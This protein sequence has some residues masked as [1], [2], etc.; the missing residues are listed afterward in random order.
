M[1]NTF[2]YKSRITHISGLRVVTRVL[3]HLE[4][5]LMFNTFHYKSRITHISGLRVVTRVLIHEIRIRFEKKSK[6]IHVIDI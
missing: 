1:F 2:H 6:H 4:E 5:N 3:I